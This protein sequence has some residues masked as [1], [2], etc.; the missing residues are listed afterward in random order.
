ML[1]QIIGLIVP[2]IPNET[3]LNRI[4]TK[5]P[6]YAVER[7]EAFSKYGFKPMNGYLKGEDGYPY[8]DYGIMFEPWN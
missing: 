6:L 8:K 5:V 2:Y 4:I 3:G 1:E 7:I